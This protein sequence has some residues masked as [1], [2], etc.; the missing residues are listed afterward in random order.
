MKRVLVPTDFSEFS[1]YA[2]AVAKYIAKKKNAIIKLLHVIEEPYTPKFSAT[3]DM[4][5]EDDMHKIFILKLMEKTTKRLHKQAEKVS[6]DGIKCETDVVI[7]R[8]YTGINNEVED[9]EAGLVVMGSK[10][11]GS[12]IDDFFIGSTAEKVIRKSKV[13]V[14]TVKSKPEDFRL[15][16]IV[17]ASDF[18]ED[19]TH[20]LQRVVKF[21]EIF[22]A[23]LHLLRVNTPGKFLSSSM[24]RS[25][26][27]EI[28]RNYGLDNNYSVNVYA[29][30]SEEEGIRNF[31][32]EIDADLVVLGTHGR[33]GFSQFFKS[34]IAEDVA[35]HSALPV[36]TYNIPY[37]ETERKAETEEGTAKKPVSE[38]G[39]QAEGKPKKSKPSVAKPARSA[40]KKSVKGAVPKKVSEKGKTL[41]SDDKK[42]TPAKPAAKTSKKVAEP[43]ERKTKHRDALKRETGTSSKKKKSDK[44]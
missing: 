22:N 29:D 16:N 8:A 39:K 5:F 20:L 12:D 6:A 1:D 23:K 28:I 42:T 30:S 9:S 3:G 31:A 38:K 24:S 2:I 34:S 15:K 44:E 25:K 35:G 33:T 10:G 7:D 13:P 43:V 32:S 17:F 40:G 21:A 37:E 11:T 18:E 26:I 14:L 36:L 41:P 27:D 19:I 4:V